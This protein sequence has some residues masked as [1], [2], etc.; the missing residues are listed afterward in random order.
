MNARQ[1]EAF[2]SAV[3]L[4]YRQT[5][6]EEAMGQ[7][8]DKG[9]FDPSSCDESKDMTFVVEGVPLTLRHY[10]SQYGN[11]AWALFLEKP[12]KYGVPIAALNAVLPTSAVVLDHN[13]G[14][15]IDVELSDDPERSGESVTHSGEV[16]LP[17]GE[18][19]NLSVRISVTKAN[20]WNIKAATSKKSEGGGGSKPVDIS[21]LQRHTVTV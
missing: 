11:D 15:R 1:E 17:N 13:S 2:S 18:I 14:E 4:G 19:R 21:R 3:A 9:K 20:G 5:R 10:R 12:S 8:T 16:L 7:P 6:L